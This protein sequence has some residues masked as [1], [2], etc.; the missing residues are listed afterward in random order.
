MRDEGRPLARHR[1]GTLQG[2]SLNAAYELR[3]EIVARAKRAQEAAQEAAHEAAAA[4]AA[5]RV[6]ARRQLARSQEELEAGRAAG[7]AGQRRR[8]LGR[9]DTQQARVD[10][11]RFA[12]ARGRITVRQSALQRKERNVWV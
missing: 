6:E 10:G 5:A 11:Q 9:T 3:G 8:R 1:S 7:A 2:R 4:E 12:Q